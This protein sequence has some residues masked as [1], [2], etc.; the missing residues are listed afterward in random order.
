MSRS[1]SLAVCNNEIA[2][3]DRMTGLRIIDAAPMKNGVHVKFLSLSSLHAIRCGRLKES[4]RPGQGTV[5]LRYDGHISV[6][7]QFP[8]SAHLGWRHDDVV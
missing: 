6:S 8:E 5:A 2:M 7:D 4:D 3:G 1:A